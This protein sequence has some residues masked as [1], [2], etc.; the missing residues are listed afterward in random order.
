TAVGQTTHLA[1]R[2]EQMAA[3]GTILITPGTL[4]LAESVIRANP[5]GPRA[6]KGL[7]APLSV[8]ELVGAVHAHALLRAAATRRLSRFVGRRAR[9]GGRPDPVVARRA[10]GRRSVPR[11]RRPG[12]Q[13]ARARR[14]DARVPQGGRPPAPAARL[15]EPPVGGRRDP[16][17]PGRPARAG[18]LLAP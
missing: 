9:R 4:R 10:A 11:A 14:A 6:V 16:G 17:R 3:P 15:R 7:D 13:A 12:A 2:M 5:L 18:P 1:A 8:H